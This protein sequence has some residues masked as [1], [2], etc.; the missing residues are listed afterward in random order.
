MTVSNAELFEDAQR[1]IPGGVN[2]PVRSF[3]AVGGTPY[4]VARA[5]GPYVWDV[6]GQRYIDLVQSYG[7][8]IVGHAH[9]AVV[10]TIQQAAALGTSYGAPTAREVQLAEELRARVPSC[11]LSRLVSSGTEA[12]M[13]AIRVAR[14][15]TGR[16]KVL[17]F[18]GNY[19]GHGDALLAAG[20]SGVATLGLSGSAGVTEKAVSE[21]IVAPFN[22]VP[23]LDGDVACVIVEPV[24]ANM[25]LVAPRLG[26]LEGLRSACDAAGALL[27]FDEVITGFRL[28]TGWTP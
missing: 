26:F 18:A 4:F 7:A 25:G 19:H 9:P 14:G 20:G 28:V 12:T 27:V 21:T 2:S 3:S 15:F 1:V 23:E 6:E 11:E 16:T 22:V 10:D 24:G 8:I 13:S 17:K 5:K